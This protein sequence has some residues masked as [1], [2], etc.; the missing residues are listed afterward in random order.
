MPV[1]SRRDWMKTGFAAVA[2]VP[3]I[4]WPFP[5]TPPR[6]RRDADGVIRY[7][8]KAMAGLTYRPVAELINELE[9]LR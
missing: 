2:G 6:T 3:F 8:H 7:A 1:V 9:K 5:G 4:R